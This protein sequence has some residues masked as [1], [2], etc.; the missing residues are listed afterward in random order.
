MLGYKEDDRLGIIEITV[1]G[2]VTAKEFEAVAGRIEA[3]IAR[4]GKVRVLERIEDFKGMEARA[5]WED[6]VFSLRHL[7]DF[8]RCAVVSDK[9]WSTIWSELVGPLMRCEVEHFSLGEMEAARA[10]LA[11]PEGA[12]DV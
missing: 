4:H 11:W 1:S 9:Q 2:R 7:N 3:A 5:F 6:L 10:W 8:S 12:A